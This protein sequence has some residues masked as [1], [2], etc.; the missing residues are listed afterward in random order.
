MLLHGEDEPDDARPKSQLRDAQV[1]PAGR[2]STAILLK[3]ARDSA[4]RAALNISYGS[5]ASLR[6][7][8]RLRRMSAM[9]SM[10]TESARRNE[11][12]M[13]QFP[14]KLAHVCRFRAIPPIGSTWGLIS[15]AEADF[16]NEPFPTPV[17]LHFAPQ[18]SNHSFDD[19]TAKALT[20]RLLGRRTI[21]LRPAKYQLS[22]RLVLPF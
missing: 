6:R 15:R 22:I 4:T 9:P 8:A 5:F 21:G 14:T 18:L 2:P 12:T 7:A 10:A 17:E 19:P 1:I 16:A 3:F 11:P 20:R 13:C